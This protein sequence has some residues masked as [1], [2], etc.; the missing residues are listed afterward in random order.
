MMNYI[1]VLNQVRFDTFMKKGLLETR[2]SEQSSL[3][4]GADDSLYIQLESDHRIFGPFRIFDVDHPDYYVIKGS[5][6]Q[7]KSDLLFTTGV[8]EQ[9]VIDSLSVKTTAGK[10]FDDSMGVISNDS[11]LTGFVCRTLK[12]SN[13]TN[14]FSL[15]ISSLPSNIVNDIV[16]LAVDAELS[17]EVVKN[18]III[19]NP[20]KMPLSLLFSN[21]SCFERQSVD[22]MN[23]YLVGSLNLI[24][25][26][27]SAVNIFSI[28]NQSIS[29][30]ISTNQS[31]FSDYL[32]ECGYL[33]QYCTPK[34]IILSPLSYSIPI[35]HDF[36]IGCKADLQE[37]NHIVQPV[38]EVSS[39]D[40]DPS[41]VQYL[42]SDLS[43]WL[44]NKSGYAI[45]Q[46]LDDG[47]TIENDKLYDVHIISDQQD[48]TPH[49]SSN[50][51]LYLYWG[52]Y[53]IRYYQIEPGQLI[54]GSS[55]AF[56][57]C[58]LAGLDHDIIS[59]LNDHLQTIL[60][61]ARGDLN[62]D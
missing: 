23:G 43:K 31:L 34:Q 45:S 5:L 42:L 21:N 24:V 16:Q 13:L 51:Q 33:I 48:V 55:E 35:V 10:S 8:T 28:N 57:N 61:I 14:K 39:D 40:I 27:R 11:F 9:S 17:P 44:F 30:N 18:N 46:L 25:N 52:G 49:Y 41:F 29:F 19:H 3:S 54:S 56:I 59:L 58:L 60:S 15:D 37:L 62:N 2:S 20:S 36:Y 47:F 50:Y 6:F 32:S 38:P 7:Y 26:R 12:Y 53:E 4:V 1:A 22:F